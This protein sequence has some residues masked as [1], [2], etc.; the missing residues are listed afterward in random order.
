MTEMTTRSMLVSVWAS[1]SG[2][3]NSS[4]VVTA[5][6]QGPGITASDRSRAIAHQP[7]TAATISPSA[8]T[9]PAAAGFR[10]PWRRALR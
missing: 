8:R 2:S 1:W 4:A 10:P 7:T 3:V 9:R 5:T 6:V